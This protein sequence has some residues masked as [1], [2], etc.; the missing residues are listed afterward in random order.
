MRVILVSNGPG[1]HPHPMP[2]NFVIDD[3]GRY[4]VITFRKGQK[5]KNLERDPRAALLVESGIAY[6]ELKSVLA[7]ADAEIIDDAELVLQTMVALIA[8][9]SG[10][11][12]EQAVRQQALSNADKRVAIRFKPD[13]YIS[14]DHSKL[15]GRY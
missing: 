13:S 14:W 15:D 12:D 10:V 11:M 5:V 4:V 8:K 7:Y 2:M 1:G 6:A 3:E 9:E